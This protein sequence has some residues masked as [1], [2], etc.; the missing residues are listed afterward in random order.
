[1][2]EEGFTQTITVAKIKATVVSKV[3]CNIAAAAMNM[4]DNGNGN[5]NGNGNGNGNGD[6]DSDSDGDGYGN[7]DNNSDRYGK[8]KCST[9]PFFNT[10]LAS[11]CYSCQIDR[12]ITFPTPLK[13]K[14]SIDASTAG[15]HKAPTVTPKNRKSSKIGSSANAS[16]ASYFLPKKR[17]QSDDISAAV[18]YKVSTI[19]PKNRKLTKNGSVAMALTSGTAMGLYSTI[20]PTSSSNVDF[21]T[22]GTETSGHNKDIGLVNPLESTVEEDAAAKSVAVIV[23]EVPWNNPT[24]LSELKVAG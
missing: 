10:N 15:A 9:C 13:R 24:A 23:S 12:L 21:F 14:L 2:N 7:G 11:I 17:K 8:W 18:T 1:M 3:A 20:T 19:T 6:D 4:D 5:S 16:I 22:S